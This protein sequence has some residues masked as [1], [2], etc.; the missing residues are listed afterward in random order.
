MTENPNNPRSLHEHYHR[1]VSD[2]IVKSIFN[3]GKSKEGE[4][5]KILKW[6]LIEEMTLTANY[7]MYATIFRVDDPTSQSQPIES[8]QGTHR[9]TSAPRTPNLAT[10]EGESSAQ[11][12][13]TKKVKEHMVDEEIEQLLEGN[14]NVDVETFMDEV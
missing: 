7:R 14:N 2:E 8:T 12:K 10:T 6:M 4:G 5:M 13:P 1:V 3:S 11:H 9:T